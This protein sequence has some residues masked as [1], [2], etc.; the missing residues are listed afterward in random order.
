MT[1]T[2][3]LSFGSRKT[4]A[5]LQPCCFR[6][7]APL[8]EKVFQKRSKSPIF[9]VARTIV[10]SSVGTCCCAV[11][12]TPLH[13]GRWSAGSHAPSGRVAVLVVE[14]AGRAS[15]DQRN[16]RDEGEEAQG[17]RP[18]C[19]SGA[20]RGAAACN[21]TGYEAGK[22]EERWDTKPENDRAHEPEST[23]HDGN[24]R[25]RVALH[26]LNGRV[27]CRLAAHSNGQLPVF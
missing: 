24:D 5:P 6:F 18:G 7:S 27:G 11:H 22:R 23:E 21:V 25:D 8:V 17:D 16:V 4:C 9:A 26:W 14:C 13:H 19:G 15:G 10:S 3:S 2:R 1:Q 12:P 20:F